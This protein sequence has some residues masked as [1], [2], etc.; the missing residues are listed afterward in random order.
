MAF[1]YSHKL[2]AYVHKNMH[3]DVYNSSIH[4]F[5]IL[6]QASKVSFKQVNRKTVVQSEEGIQLSTKQK[7]VEAM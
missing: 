4:N 5:Q 1:K 2:K 6:K 7:Y 3:M